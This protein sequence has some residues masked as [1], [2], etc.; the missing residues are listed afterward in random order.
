MSEN[1]KEIDSLDYNTYFI[2]RDALLVSMGK[3]SKINPMTLKWKT[4]GELWM[5]PVITIALAPSRNSFKLLTG[6]IQEFTIN[7]PSNKIL[8]TLDICGTLSGRNI[9]KIKEADLEIISGKKIRVPTLKDCNLN[10]ECKIVH[11]CKSG[12]MA[13]HH[14]FFGEILIA[15]ASKE[16]IK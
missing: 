15:Y 10:Y 4:I 2:E 6:E 13:S 5:L 12:Q 14:L 9:D 8:N 1:R 11:S 7:I 16:I 3:D